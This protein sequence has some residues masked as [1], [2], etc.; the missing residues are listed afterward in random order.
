MGRWGGSCTYQHQPA[1]VGLEG[2][3]VPHRQLEG[4][5]RLFGGFVCHGEG[6]SWKG[7]GQLSGRRGTGHGVWE[8]ESG[9]RDGER[10]EEG[11]G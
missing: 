6:Q 2:L 8:R 1:V 7:E 3:E 4:P 9:S 11:S 5:Q 10:S